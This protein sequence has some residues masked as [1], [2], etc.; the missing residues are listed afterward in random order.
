MSD[1]EV[2]HKQRAVIKFLIAEREAVG[3]IYKHLKM[4]TE[5]VLSTAQVGTVQNV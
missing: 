4:F 5:A 2:Y 3:N 1:L